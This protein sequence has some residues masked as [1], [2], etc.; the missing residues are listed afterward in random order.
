MQLLNL[1]CNKY[2]VQVVALAL[3]PNHYHKVIKTIFGLDVSDWVKWA[4][5]IYAQSFNKRY[6]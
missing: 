5:G 3:M 4:Q 1:G 2:A 6:E